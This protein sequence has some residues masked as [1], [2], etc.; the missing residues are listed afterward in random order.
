MKIIREVP[1]EGGKREMK[2]QNRQLM[3]NLTGVDQP[4]ILRTFT[5]IFHAKGV[6]IEELEQSSLHD[7]LSIHFLLDLNRATASE[8]EI[9]KELL[10]EAHRLDLAVNLGFSSQGA[11][12]RNATGE[13]YVLTFFGGTT[14]LYEL[15]KQMTAEEVRILSVLT[16]KHH[17]ARSFEMNIEI[18]DASHR[19][20]FKMAVMQRSRELGMDLALQRVEAYRKSKR[21][22]FFDMD[23]TLI[24]MEIIDEMARGAGVYRE[25]ARITEKAMQGQFDFEESLIQRVALLKGLTLEALDKIRDNIPLSEGVEDLTI[26]LKWLG[27]KMGIVTGGFDFFAN[28]MK[29]RLGFDFVAANQLEIKNGALTGRVKGEIIGAAQKAQIVSRVSCDLG[30]PTEQIVVVGDGA[31]DAL[32]IGQ[33]GLGIAYNAKKALDRVASA[34]LGKSQLVH[35]YHLLGI[36]E[37]NIKEAMTCKPA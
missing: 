8:E 35:I 26:T 16:S 15:S 5:E 18:P 1:G 2:G 4:G 23:S 29:E 19:D 12:A 21:M 9:A 24:D 33:A 13:R 37:E 32:M 6:D 14:G 7:M 22:I 20:R 36:T 27:F 30:I 17:S 25:V 28:H 34:K 3:A 11:G 10:Y 31:N